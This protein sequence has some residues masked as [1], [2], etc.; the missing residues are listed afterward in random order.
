MRKAFLIP[1]LFLSA[2]STA[3]V[4][5]FQNASINFQ[6]IVASINADIAVV[7]PIVAADCADLQKWAMLI[8]PFVPSSGKAQ[9]Y[10]G[11]ANG[12][13]TSYCQN[14]PTDINSTA[15]AVIKAVQA[16]QAGYDLVSSGK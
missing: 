12:A 4:E 3:Q 6:K 14:V 2:C 11:A 15:A 16:A 9:Q 7:A 8:A 13:L 10:F 5:K 1:L